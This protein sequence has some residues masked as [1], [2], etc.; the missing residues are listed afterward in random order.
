MIVKGQSTV[1]AGP[2]ELWAVLSDPARLAEA[3]PGVGEVSIED[4]RRFSAVAHPL[5][6]LGATRVALEFEIVE[7][8]TN[9]LVRIIGTGSAGENLLALSVTL[10]LTGDA[11][12]TTAG[13]T[14][15]LH[16]RG[17]LSSLL[18][19]G[20][21]E[22]FNEQVEAVLATAAALSGAGHGG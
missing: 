2:Q 4:E 3:L 7:Q 11:A 8:R 15:E 5:T 16:L 19:R 17:G 18:Q 9:E 10:E 20:L 1:A 12:A 14:A 6:A 22:L 21:G 13:W